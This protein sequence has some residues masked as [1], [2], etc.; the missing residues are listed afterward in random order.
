MVETPSLA[1]TAQRTLIS[2]HEVVENGPRSKTQCDR[3][4]QRIE[5][6]QPP[7]CRVPPNQVPRR[8]K[9]RLAD[10]DHI[11][12]A[13]SHVAEK[14]LADSLDIVFVNQPGPQLASKDGLNLDDR[15]T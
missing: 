15:E 10:R 4:L 12:P 9:V 7:G 6:S 3:K 2:S 14:P 1:A 13:P 8:F 11:D 5:R